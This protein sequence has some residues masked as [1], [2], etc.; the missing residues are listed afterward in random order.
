MSNLSILIWPSPV[1]LRTK[2]LSVEESRYKYN[3]EEIN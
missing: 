1:S 2:S 3:M